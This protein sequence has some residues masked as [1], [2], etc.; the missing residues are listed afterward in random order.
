MVRVEPQAGPE[1]TR[2]LSAPSGDGIT[3]II[4]TWNSRRTIG[5]C[6]HTLRG[7]GGQFVG[8][9]KVIDNASSDDTAELIAADYPE[10][11]LMRNH[12][13]RGFAAAANRGIAG[14]RT[15]F[16]IIL[17][18]DTFISPQIAVELVARLAGLP[19]VGIATCRLR[20]CRGHEHAS[21]SL[22]YPGDR[23]SVVA[24]AGAGKVI[25]VACVY[26]ALMA[27][28]M[29]AVRQVGPL[30]ED[31]FMYYEDADWC[32]RMRGRGWRV[33]VCADLV[34]THIGGAS[35]DGVL[36]RRTAERY[37]RSELLFHQKRY[38]SGRR[39]WLLAKRSIA[40]LLRL[41]GYSCMCAASSNP[42]R[43]RKWIRYRA[44][45]EV[46]LQRALRRDY[47]G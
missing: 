37:F 26:G 30:D 19:D 31:F 47:S 18:P 38:P 42:R 20:D 2:C 9:V 27:V 10:V 36:S 11:E 22:R 7:E 21:Y 3:F 17:N 34:A 16:A 12:Y 39:L 35:S 4:V 40:A 29:Q 28:R 23:R 24:H 15:P 33:V 14:V 8:P 25:D 1:G 46:L 5:R 44:Q 41:G 32:R 13:N 43:W 45:V 6:L